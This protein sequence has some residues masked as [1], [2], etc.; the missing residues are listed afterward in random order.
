MEREV[1]FDTPS[2]LYTVINFIS[3][4]P[5]P[6]EFFAVPNTFSSRCDLKSNFIAT[7]SPTIQTPHIQRFPCQIRHFQTDIFLIFIPKTR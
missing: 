7:L 4:T 5:I 1:C 2:F 6:V 3:D